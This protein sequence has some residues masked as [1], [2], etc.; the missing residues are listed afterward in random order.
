MIVGL[1]IVVGL[2]LL[3]PALAVCT[4]RWHD[5]NFSGTWNIVLF[6]PYVQLI[7]LVVL[8]FSRSDEGPNKYG[9]L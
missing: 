2:V 7:A 8:G 6:I 5:F 1:S 3:Y 9:E 4:K